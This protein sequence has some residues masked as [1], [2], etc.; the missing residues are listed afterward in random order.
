MRGIL[1]RQWFLVALG[2]VLGLGFFLPEPFQAYADS[3][4][5]RNSIVASVLFV[6]ALPLQTSV[7]W[8]TLRSP[9]PALLGS[10]I[11]MGL[12]PLIAWPIAGLLEGDLAVGLLVAATA[13]CTLASAAVWTRRAGGNDAAAI[14]VT[15]LTNATCFLVTPFWLVLMTRQTAELQ[16]SEMIS[17]L[18]LLVVLP[19]TLAQ[20]LRLSPRVA[21]WS[22]AQKRQ[23]STLA[24]CGILSMVLIGAV[25]AE[26]NL[27]ETDWR[28][29][30]GGLDLFVMI[31]VA[32][33]LHVLVL[34][35]GFGLAKATRM[36]RANC[37]AVAFSGSQKTLMVGLYIALRYYGG[38]TILPMVAYHVGQLIL[39][40]LVADAIRRSEERREIRDSFRP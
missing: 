35:I 5:V 13:P 38:L 17:K 30:V 11:N 2:C 33:L 9:G 16:L 25:N 8:Q 19:M 15:I 7:V 24:Q 3:A 37:I 31:L 23:L 21:R 34:G 14:L 10:A 1:Y 29:A 6:M 22:T 36:T 4:L 27:A 20:L 18:G 40:T 26:R 32:S 28:E 12:L 39:D